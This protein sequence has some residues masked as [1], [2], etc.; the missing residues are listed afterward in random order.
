MKN[1]FCSDSITAS[2]IKMPPDKLECHSPRRSC[3]HYGNSDLQ[4]PKKSRLSFS[5]RLQ[6]SLDFFGSFRSEFPYWSRLRREECYSPENVLAINIEVL[7]QPKKFMTWY[8]DFFICLILYG[9]EAGCYQYYQVTEDFFLKCI[10][11]E[12][13]DAAQ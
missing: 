1:R 5:L 4:E 9:K 13:A 6:D 7:K 12:L 11:K 10:T 3:D 8:E 2:S